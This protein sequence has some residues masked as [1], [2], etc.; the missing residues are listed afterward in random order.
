MGF[1]VLK[2]FQGGLSA[3]H[4]NWVQGSHAREGFVRA[5]SYLSMKKNEERHAML[6]CLVEDSKRSKLL[7]FW[8]K[9]DSSQPDVRKYTITMAHP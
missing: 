3:Q 7:L 4:L 6:V 9:R 5:R 1:K 8:S 2:A